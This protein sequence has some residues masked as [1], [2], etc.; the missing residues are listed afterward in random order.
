M[1]QS[2]HDNFAKIVLLNTA[3]HHRAARCNANR[4]RWTVAT[5]RNWQWNNL[6]GPLWMWKRICS[7]TWQDWKWDYGWT[8]T[9]TW[10]SVNKALLSGVRCVGLSPLNLIPCLKKKKTISRGIGQLWHIVLS[11]SRQSLLP[12]PPIEVREASLTGSESSRRLDMM[13]GPA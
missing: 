2:H 7:I 5:W 4:K 11:F 13:Y 3:A 10:F 1:V 8:W 6:I 9:C 12:F